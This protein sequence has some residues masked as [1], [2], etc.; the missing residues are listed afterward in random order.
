MSSPISS[1]PTR[2]APPAQLSDFLASGPVVLFFYPGRH[3][4]RLHEGELPLP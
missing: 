1:S 2:R 3:D 4:V